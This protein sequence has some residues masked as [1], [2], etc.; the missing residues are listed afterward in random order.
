MMDNNVS[1]QEYTQAVD[2]DAVQFYNSRSEYRS[3]KVFIKVFSSN[4]KLQV[5][6][7]RRN[8]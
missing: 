8:E 4:F 2:L 6:I 7:W 3:T 5:N 1:L